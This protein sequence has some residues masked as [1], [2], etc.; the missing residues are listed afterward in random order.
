MVMEYVVTIGIVASIFLL[1]N[2][3]VGVAERA[4]D[5]TLDKKYEEAL[6]LPPEEQIVE[7]EEVQTKIDEW[8]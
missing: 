4:T 5:F 1:L 7:E 2:Y 6:T 8:V 3:L